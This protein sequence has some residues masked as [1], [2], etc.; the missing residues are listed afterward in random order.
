M[1]KTI[2]STIIQK[3]VVTLQLVVHAETE[4]GQQSNDSIVPGLGRQ[5]ER[6]NRK[7]HTHR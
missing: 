7:L 2:N 4:G 6:V 3:L 5:E 1:R